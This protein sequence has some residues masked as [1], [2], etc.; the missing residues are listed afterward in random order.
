MAC[1]LV[2][3]HRFPAFPERIFMRALRSARGDPVGLP[4]TKWMAELGAL[5]CA[6]TPRSDGRAPSAMSATSVAAAADS[7]RNLD[8]RL[9]IRR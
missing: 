3:P 2:R 6:Q 4:V 5:G 7:H 9:L 1:Q 8:R